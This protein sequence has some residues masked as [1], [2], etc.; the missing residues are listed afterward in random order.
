MSRATDAMRLSG[1]ALILGAAFARAMTGESG[2]PYWDVDPLSQAAPETLLAPTLGFTLDALVWLGAAGAVLGEALAGRPIMWRTG[3]LAIVG[4]AGAFLHGWILPPFGGH[5]LR[6]ELGSLVSGSA[7][8]AAMIGAWALIHLARDPIIRRVG[9]AAL[10]GFSLLLVGVGAHDYFV[11]H[12]ATVSQFEADPAGALQRHAIEPG[13]AGA[14]VFERRLRQAEATAWFGLSNVYG[15]FVAAGFVAWLVFGAACVRARRTLGVA[16]C[17]SASA[18]CGAGLVM[19][20]SK[21]AIGAALLAGAI[22]VVTSIPRLRTLTSRLGPLIALGA[23]ATPLAIVVL[24]GAVGSRLAEL[25]LLFRWHYAQAAARIF[26]EHPVAGVGPGGFKAAYAL[27]KVP[28]NPESV[29][30]AHSIMLDWA[31]TLGIFGLAWCAILLIRVAQL[32][33]GLSPRH[34]VSDVQ[35]AHERLR[36]VRNVAI[37]SILGAILLAWRLDAPVTTRPE[38]LLRAL[39]AGAWI[40]ALFVPLPAARLGAIGAALVVAIHLQLEMTG[41]RTTSALLAFLLI[42]LGAAPD[43]APKAGGA[44][45]RLALAFAPLAGLV[46][47]SLAVWG[48]SP[49]ARWQA[50]LRAAAEPL[51]PSPNDPSLPPPGVLDRSVESLLEADAIFPSETDPL[52]QAIRLR[53]TAAGGHA[54]AGQDEPARAASDNAISLA[55]RGT[56][57]LPGR[58]VSWSRL[59]HVHAARFDLFGDPDDLHSA[60]DAWTQAS[61]LD[62]TA[63]APAFHAWQLSVRLGR[64]SEGERWARRVLEIDAALA[65]DPLVR[66]SEP[67]RRRVQEALG[68]P[69]G[70]PSGSE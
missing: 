57:R 34:A 35:P 59:A 41:V 65:L 17:L 54:G 43:D 50:N 8:A 4:A 16:L 48:I 30:S 5:A 61:A 49:A 23:I 20:G 27:A 9:V 22:V 60:L 12:A 32:G 28:S 11:E 67:D 2:T 46:I 31:T 53:L 47:V 55:R 68:S 44:D 38:M 25:S 37:V 62:P 36:T 70:A 45:R 39:F 64:T 33:R 3:A 26:A 10:L 52:S 15:T 6:G 7:W 18:L 19:S 1:F 24:R 63:L 21:G 40:G 14:R 51:Y 58:A 56:E 66:L 42:A 29:D 69:A 13:S